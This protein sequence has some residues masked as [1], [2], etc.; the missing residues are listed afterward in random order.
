MPKSSPLVCNFAVW[1]VVLSGD[2][3]ISLSLFCSY[4][5]DSF[6]TKLSSTPAANLDWS[7]RVEVDRGG[8][9]HMKVSA[10]PEQSSLVVMLLDCQ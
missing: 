10:K 3:L 6:Y 7:A 2:T 8:Y 1:F 4:A 9:S 5:V